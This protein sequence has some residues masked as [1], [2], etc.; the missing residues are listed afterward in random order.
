MLGTLVQQEIG[1]AVAI[2]AFGR[3]IG[4]PGLSRPAG[5]LKGVTHGG[6]VDSLSVRRCHERFSEVCAVDVPQPPVSALPWRL[7][8]QQQALVKS[9]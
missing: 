4:R 9:L 5:T 1:R 8:E 2:K 6:E 3:L 7:L